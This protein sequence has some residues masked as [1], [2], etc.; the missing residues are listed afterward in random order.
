MR[1]LRLLGVGALM[2]LTVSACTNSAD[3]GSTTAETSKSTDAAITV[4]DVKG[5]TVTFD[6]P[7]ERIIMGEGRGLFATSILNKENPIDKVVALGSDLTT[8]APSFKEKLVEKL[9]AVAELP[10]IGGIA[11]GDVT[12]EN[13]IAHNPDALVMTA[14]HYDAAETTG[15][16]EKIDAAGIK[17]IVTDFRQH[18]MT[19]TT[20][21]I[22]AL[23]E[24]FGKTEEAKKF[25][26]DWQETVDRITERTSKLSDEERPKT[27]LWRAAG[28]KDCCATVNKSNLGEFVNAAGGDNMGDHILDTESGDITAEKVIAENPDVIIA[29]GGSWD[30]EKAGSKDEEKKQ[31]IPHVEL[32][33]SA[34][35]ERAA[36]TLRGLL[37]TNGFDQL[38]APKQEKLYAVWHQ[39][40]DSPMN[41]LALEQFAVWLHPELFSDIDVNAHWE[42]AHEEFQAFPASGIFFTG[43][44]P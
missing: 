28:L 17:Y 4:T 2:A 21:S 6:T 9:P 5:R 27:L 40:Y 43:M 12:V 26:T 10:E 44:N 39:F 7:P 42:K 8:A 37:Q 19:N 24:L 34:T 22:T 31:A 18:P 30:P 16:L 1:K 36:E 35:K 38:D 14:D 15:M 23:G 41:Y 33:Y 11:K 3:T 20:T 13:L 29:T 32:G 25:N